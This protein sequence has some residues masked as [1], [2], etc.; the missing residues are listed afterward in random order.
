MGG[1]TLLVRGQI[2]KA[3]IMACMALMTSYSMAEGEEGGAGGVPY[4][5]L[6]PSFVTNF[7]GPADVD[8]PHFVKVDISLRVGSNDMVDEVKY[9]S[10]A[11]RN[12][13][14]LLL[15]AQTDQVMEAPSAQ[16][17]LRQ[18]I[19]KGVNKILKHEDGDKVKVDDV[20]FTSFVIQQ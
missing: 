1:A 4:V 10:A 7:G 20:F 11:L 9:H 13:I 14:L 8:N 17:M 18:E 19:L 15:A 6:A 2:W 12:Y 3:L 5:A 16:T